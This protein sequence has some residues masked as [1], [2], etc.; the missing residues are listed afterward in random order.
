MAS[1][2]RF[3]REGSPDGGQSG[4]LLLDVVHKLHTQAKASRLVER[5]SNWYRINA[6]AIQTSSTTPIYLVK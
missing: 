3:H 4:R 5:I 1:S 2:K 6:Y